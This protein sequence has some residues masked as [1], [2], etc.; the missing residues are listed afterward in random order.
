MGEVLARDASTLLK[1]NQVL[2]SGGIAADAVLNEEFT[3]SDLVGGEYGRGRVSGH[4]YNGTDD[5]E[6][7]LEALADL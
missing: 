2:V 6:R 7:F 5:V 1:D 4:L 3:T